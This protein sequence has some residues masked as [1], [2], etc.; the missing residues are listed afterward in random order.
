MLNHVALKAADGRWHTAYEVPGTTVL[1]SVMTALSA[2]G[3]RHEAERLNRE[4]AQRNPPVV[5]PIERRIPA[6]FYTDKDAS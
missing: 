1:S 5:D 2:R 4:Q 6:G 3:A